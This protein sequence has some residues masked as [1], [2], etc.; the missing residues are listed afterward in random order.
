MSEPRV[1]LLTPREAEVLDLL[2][3]AMATPAI[4]ARL[5]ITA[6][7]VEAHLTKIRDKLGHEPSEDVNL[8]VLLVIWWLKQRGRSSRCRSAGAH[9]EAV[10]GDY[11]V[12]PI[13]EPG[14][15]P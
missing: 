11:W 10:Y 4:A 6:K 12:V 8:R 5:C 14:G 7:T 3:A 2:S 13:G 1:V 15:E 9:H